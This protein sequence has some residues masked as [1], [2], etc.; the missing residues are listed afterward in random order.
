MFKR[1]LSVLVV[2]AV[3]L[4]SAVAFSADR[5]EGTKM[6]KSD[7]DSAF[8]VTVPAQAPDFLN[9]NAHILGAKKFATGNVIVILESK[10]KDE[11]VFVLAVWMVIDGKPHCVAIQVSYFPIGGFKK[12]VPPEDQIKTESMIDVQ[13]FKD[14]K[15]SGVLTRVKDV[16]S[17]DPVVQYFDRLPV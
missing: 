8:A 5:P 14:F 15:P 10:N 13:F 7:G 9:W 3:L 12:S 4:F 6:L 11:H 2:L 17:L 1:M 16:P